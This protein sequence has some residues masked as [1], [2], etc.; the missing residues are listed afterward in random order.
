MATTRETVH[1]IETHLLESLYAVEE[2]L[3]AMRDEFGADG[4]LGGPRDRMA[5]DDAKATKL[6]IERRLAAI[7]RA[8][9]GVAS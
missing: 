1:T 7:D 9:T 4:S 5:L 2:S 6:E 3:A 8:R